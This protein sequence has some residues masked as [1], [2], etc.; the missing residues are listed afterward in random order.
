MKTFTRNSLLVCCSHYLD[1]NLKLIRDERIGGERTKL[2]MFIRCFTDG[3]FC[4]SL[5]PTDLNI[6]RRSAICATLN[7]CTVDPH[8]WW[9]KIINYKSQSKQRNRRFPPNQ[10]C[11]LNSKPLQNRNNMVQIIF[12]KYSVK[13][14][15]ISVRSC[16]TIIHRNSLPK[17]KKGIIWLQVIEVI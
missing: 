16:K 8:M 2:C 4:A 9:Q 17:H 13:I 15:R 5:P 6:G 1:E 14:W 11:E 7:C 12:Q 10:S 3:F